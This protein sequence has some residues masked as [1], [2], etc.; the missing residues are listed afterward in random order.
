MQDVDRNAAAFIELE[1]RYGAHNYQPLDLVVERAEGVWL[2]DGSG[3]RYLD[4]VSAYSA[5]NQGHCHPRIRAALEEQAKKVTLTS[6]A[7]RNDRLGPFLKRLTEFCGY[8]SALPMNTG[9]EAVETAIKLARRYAYERKRVAPDSAEIIVFEN[10]F[11]GRT[12]AAI[13]AS[14]TEQYRHDFGPFTPGFVPVPYG[15]Y[16]ALAAAINERTCA[17]LIEPVQGE[18][19]VIVPPPGF[20][21]RA[22]GLC[23]EHRVL[24]MADEIQTGL[25]RTGDLFACDHDGIK[26]DIMIAGKALGGGYYPVSA[27]LASRDLMQLFGPGDHGSTFGGNPLAC[28]VSLASLDVIE[29]ENLPARA[30]YSGA[31]LM[32]GLRDLASPAIEEIRGRGLLIGLQL[33]VPA[34]RVA[35]LLLERGVVA[36][37]THEN[38]LRIAP[39][40]VIEDA[41]IDLVLKAADDALKAAL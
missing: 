28:A 40:L 19:G 12:T 17:I 23:R 31:R 29:S 20:L 13:S 11:H 36:K 32:R 1:E 30:R 25:G 35:E 37:D 4:C 39:P 6:R 33:A 14:T 18:G 15:D 38:V 2:F 26:P 3:K 27:M 21:K 16:D 22:W 41:E 24:F 8:E 34:R 9:V 7:M 10:N 5:V